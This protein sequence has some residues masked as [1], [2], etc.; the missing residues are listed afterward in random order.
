MPGFQPK[1][2]ARL[3]AACVFIAVVPL[4]FLAVA[5]YQH[6]RD[7][8]STNALHDLDRVADLQEARLDA[9]LRR[10]DD[11]IRAW[12]RP[13]A[14]DI[15]GLGSDA[16]EQTTQMVDGA[17]RTEVAR[18]DDLL[19]IS[20]LT[21]D[22][23]VRHSSDKES[24]GT[25]AD[26]ATSAMLGT[27][28]PLGVLLESPD[29]TLIHRCVAP[30]VID[31]RIVGAVAMDADLD[32][33]ATIATDFALT[34]KTGETTI[35]QRDW[36]G[37]LAHVVA[38]RRFDPG[39]LAPFAPDPAT[40]IAA[41]LDGRTE[42]LTDVRDYRGR[43][44]FAVTRPIDGTSWGMVVKID[45]AEALADIDDLRAL[46]L[47]AGAVAL[48]TAVLA[49]WFISDRLTRPLA[50]LTRTAREIAR[51]ERS[52]RA[53]VTGS[54]ELVE[55]ADAFNTMAGS[56]EDHA[57]TDSLT[58]LPN[59]AILTNS[60]D[61][62]LVRARRHGS[63]V[64]VL[65]CDIDGFKMV[66]DAMGHG[67]GDLLLKQ[68]AERLR[69]ACSDGQLACRFGGDEFVIV[70]DSVDSVHVA[71]AAA[72]HILEQL[73]GP[74]DLGGRSQHVTVSIGVATSDGRTSGEEL[75]SDADAAMYRAKERGKAR[76]ELFDTGLR[77][78]VETRL[79]VDHALRSSLATEDI[80]V[81][82]QP[83]VD[84]RDGQ[85]VRAEGLVRWRRDGVLV[86][87]SEFLAIAAESTL[88]VDLGDVV[89]ERVARDLARL[90]DHVMLNVNLSARELLDASLVTRL[91]SYLDRY[92][93]RPNRL[94][95]EVT[96]DAVFADLDRTIGVLHELRSLGVTAAID[97]F[98]TGYSSL[99]HVRQIPSTVLKID[100]SF[101][102]GVATDP[103]D[104]Q[105]AQLVV[106][107]GTQL[108]MVVV[109]EGIE[110]DEQ[111]ATL[112][113]MGCEFGQGYYFSRPVPIDHL[114]ALVG[115]IRR[116]HVPLRA[117]WASSVPG[118]GR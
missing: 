87:P 64:A 112:R 23:V 14:Q 75:L 97:D 3:A 60:L 28:R 102:A 17:L 12:A 81:H 117:P 37:D 91:A 42:R 8:L 15:Y 84:L 59:R 29:G 109:A 95:V 101:V 36:G 49:A 96:E 55:L 80:E 45:R 66:N 74:V 77:N 83:I 56:L 79:A 38:P 34:G 115:G 22:G 67:A 47:I 44:V 31:G 40:P 65:F 2:R 100:Q 32:E 21:D 94:C 70:M 51:G 33:I 99:S 105:I 71:T 46:L 93:V 35:A 103:D 82:Y 76:V 68:V 39:E 85:V 24:I 43:T 5:T 41:A 73:N 62:A 20:I 7:V 111:L 53:E 86:G 4:V 16:G 57:V 89:I 9:V 118:P 18:S 61:R 25:S 107:L 116:R 63:I 78:S 90:P 52:T 113:G 69:H 106:S 13:A 58:R 110:T 114:V 6:E 26:P 27:E 104:A 92:S 54:P 48:A 11:L 30:I 98:G 88:I 10:R 108:G 50:S 19:S 72:Q 1:L